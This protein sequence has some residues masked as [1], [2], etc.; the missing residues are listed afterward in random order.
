[1]LQRPAPALGHDPRP[2]RQAGYEPAL[3]LI[4][5][6]FRLAVADAV[7][8][9]YGHD[10]PGRRRLVGGRHRTAAMAFLGSAWANH[11]GDL[12]NLD[13]GEVRARAERERAGLS[14]RAGSGAKPGCGPRSR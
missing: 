11:L 6:I 14:R 12:I 13:A 7:G 4:L 5:A 8:I 1:M 3:D 10:Q 2:I 9:G